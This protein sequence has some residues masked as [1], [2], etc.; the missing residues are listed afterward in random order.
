MAQALPRRRSRPPP[1]MMQPPETSSELDDDRVT[2]IARPEHF[3][4][5]MRVTD[6]QVELRIE[7]LWG[8]QEVLIGTNR[9]RAPRQCDSLANALIVACEMADERVSSFRRSLANAEEGGDDAS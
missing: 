1:L 8:T 2:F 9:I 5:R 4:A 7:F 6:E 3:R